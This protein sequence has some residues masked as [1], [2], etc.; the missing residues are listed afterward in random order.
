MIEAVRS[1][2]TTLYSLPS[3]GALWA[4][5]WAMMNGAGRL[6]AIASARL[7]MWCPPVRLSPAAP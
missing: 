1:Q 7:R 2:F 4:E 5:A 3:V 6:R